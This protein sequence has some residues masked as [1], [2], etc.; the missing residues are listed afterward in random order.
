MENDEIKIKN[1]E[2]VPP[3][4]PPKYEWAE[5][6]GAEFIAPVKRKINKT[7][8]IT[9]SFT[10]YDALKYCMRME[11]EVE[12]KKAEISGLESMIKAYKDEIELIERELDVT[13]IEETFQRALHEKLKEENEKAEGL[14]EP[15]LTN[16]TKD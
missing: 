9:E 11:K 4:I 7:M 13:T 6:D 5:E 2:I 8:E 16:E 12:N 15:P 10:Y 1:E 14:K 3:A